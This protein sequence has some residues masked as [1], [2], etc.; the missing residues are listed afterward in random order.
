M[1]L[2]KF[3]DQYR[4]FQVSQC[5]TE[6]V[7]VKKIQRSW[8]WLYKSVTPE[9][10]RILSGGTELKVRLQSKS[11]ETR[12]TISEREVV[13]TS[14]PSTQGVEAGR[15]PSVQG[16]PGQCSK[17]QA[18]QGHIVRPCLKTIAKQEGEGVLGRWLSLKSTFHISMGRCIQISRTHVKSGRGSTGL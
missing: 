17:L 14:S 10:Q 7:Y 4:E 15:C 6:R 1:D 18:S 2:S 8:V 13:H 9:L 12:E 11:E 16:Q 5:Y 3:Q